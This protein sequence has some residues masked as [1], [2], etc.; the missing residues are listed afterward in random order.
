MLEQQSLTM[1]GIFKLRIE[2]DLN[3][4]RKEKFKYNNQFL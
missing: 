3:E 1:K 4:E 2:F